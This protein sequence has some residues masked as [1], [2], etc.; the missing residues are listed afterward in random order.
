MLTFDKIK[1]YYDSGLWSKTWVWDSVG[2]G[3]I[4]D[5]QYEEIIG[6]PYPTTRPVV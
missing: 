3:K 5:I 2:K 6:E 4:T 1:D